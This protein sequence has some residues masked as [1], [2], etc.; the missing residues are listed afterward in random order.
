MCKILEI[1][2]ACGHAVDFHISVC[3][4][5]FS[6]NTN[7]TN[8]PRKKCRQTPYIRVS[9]SNYCGKCIQHDTELDCDRRRQQALAGMEAV[10]ERLD[11]PNADWRLMDNDANELEQARKMLLAVD[12]ANREIM[13]GASRAFPGTSEYV[14]RRNTVGRRR[15]RGSLL[16][17]EVHAD[18]VEASAEHRS[19]GNGWCWNDVAESCAEIACAR[20]QRLG[21]NGPVEGHEC[22]DSSLPA[23]LVKEAT[24][25][26]KTSMAGEAV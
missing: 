8:R 2:H 18:M 26:G 6:R 10:Q 4:G 22:L 3:L 17:T 24:L 20:L 13:S 23:D 19:T 9:H 16:R 15:V 11:D 7:H 14:D 21:R 25:G 5:G 12:E 1:K